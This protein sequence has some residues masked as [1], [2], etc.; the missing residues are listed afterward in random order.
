MDSVINNSLRGIVYLVGLLVAC[1]ITTVISNPIAKL[2]LKTGN[3][4]ENDGAM[5]GFGTN[6]EGQSYNCN[7]LTLGENGPISK[8]PLSQTVFAYTLSYLLVLIS[9]VDKDNTGI[10]LK[11][12]PMIVLFCILIIGDFLWNM[13]NKC[14][15]NPLFPLVSG[16]IGAAIGVSWALVLTSNHLTDFYYVSGTSTKEVCSRPTNKSFKCWKASTG[17]NQGRQNPLPP[18]K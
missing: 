12:I 1:F 10:M 17:G 13:A 15:S 9:D 16:G 6:T 18:M 2:L 3:G 4:D 14:I 5:E 8:F 11:N 7:T